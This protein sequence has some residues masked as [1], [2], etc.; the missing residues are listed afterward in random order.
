MKNISCPLQES[1]SLDIK[2]GW[3]E[4]NME[5]IFNPMCYT[6]IYSTTQYLTLIRSTEYTYTYIYIYI[7]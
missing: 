2:I 7:M 4:K 5:W 3:V 6:A 1:C